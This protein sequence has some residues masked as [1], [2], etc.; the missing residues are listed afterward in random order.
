MDGVGTT[1]QMKC[2]LRRSLALSL[3]QKRAWDDPVIRAKRSA[4]IRL[5]HEDPLYLALLRR[6]R[7]E[8]SRPW[9]DIGI[10]KTEW[11]D[12]GNRRSGQPTKWELAAR[13][14]GLWFWMVPRY[15]RKVFRP[16]ASR[17]YN[18]IDRAEREGSERL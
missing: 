9:E 3:G 5:A 13:G 4:A 12:R 14:S 1:R 15:K 10:S 18:A 2:S 7:I 6:P 8:G 11:Y 17:R 16:L